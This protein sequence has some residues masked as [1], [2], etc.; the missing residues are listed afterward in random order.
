MRIITRQQ[1]KKNQVCTSNSPEHNRIK[2]F[3]GSQ[4]KKFSISF[5]YCNVSNT[6]GPTLILF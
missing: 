1:M 6:M 2:K 3:G 5:H 4:P